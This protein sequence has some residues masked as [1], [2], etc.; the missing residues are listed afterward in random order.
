MLKFGEI[1][2]FIPEGKRFYPQV[3]EWKVP[4]LN[5][6][7]KSTLYYIE[8]KN[9]YTFALDIENFDM[10]ERVIQVDYDCDLKKIMDGKPAIILL[11]SGS[12]S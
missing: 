9:E 6:Q 10:S 12:Q 8:R 7:Y 11:L 3:G 4:Y 5:F 1:F 2:G